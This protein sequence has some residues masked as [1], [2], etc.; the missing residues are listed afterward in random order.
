M[1]HVP[2]LHRPGVVERDLLLFARFPAQ[3]MDLLP[4]RIVSRSAGRSDRLQDGHA[5]GER[6][7]AGAPHFTHNKN[8]VAAELLHRDIDHRV[9]DELLQAVGEI[10][11][12]LHRRKTGGGNIAN[13]RQRNVAVGP[14]RQRP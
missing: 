4:V 10:R 2:G 9:G 13:Q 12:Q 3:N 11:G 14:H 7:R 6:Q 1:L 8:A 5:R